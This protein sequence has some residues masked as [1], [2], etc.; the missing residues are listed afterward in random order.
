M[1]ATGAHAR[2]HRY[3]RAKGVLRPLYHV[4]RIVVAVPLLAWFRLRVSGA[5]R[6]PGGGAI[7]APNH[8]SFLDVFFLGLSL[9]RPVRYMAKAEL[10]RGPLPPLLARLGAFPVRRGEADADAL[11]TACAIL[12]AG[13][14][15]VV[16][17]EGTRVDEPD[18][19]GSPHHGAG[20]LA[21]E[22]GAPIVPT[23]IEGTSHLWLGPVPKPRRV[24]ISFLEPVAVADTGDARAALAELID[25]RVWPAVQD[26]Y[27]RLAATPGVIVTALTAIGLGGLA[28]RRGLQAAKPRLVGVVEPRRVRVRKAWRRRIERLWH[29]S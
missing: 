19:L 13:G 10:F 5:E 15:L 23:A 16:F 20:R 22:S 2:A 24:Q 25:R 6:I 7:L 4:V 3:A 17:P 11:E 28:A 1:S 14:L 18:A 8:K 9:R 21:L 27:G 12:D 29:R 26:E